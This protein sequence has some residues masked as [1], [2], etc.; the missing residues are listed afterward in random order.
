MPDIVVFGSLNADLVLTVPSLPAAG[1]TV[2]GGR[3]QTHNGGKGANQAVA[4]ARL[5]GAGQVRMVGRVGDDEYGRHLRAD[6]A[7]A[8]VD[9]AAVLVDPT[10]PSG[11]ALILADAAG[12]NMIAVSP[13]AN[14]AVD[15]SDVA[16]AAADL[17]AGDVVVCQLEVPLPAV[18]ALSTAT[19][20]AGARLVCNAAPAAM[21]DADVLAALDVLVVNETEAQVVLGAVVAGPADAAA[22]ACRAGCAVVVTLGAE[23]AVYADPDGRSGQCPAP[24]VDA[25]DTVGAGDAFVGALAVALAAGASLPDAVAAGVTAGSYAVTQV[26]ARPAPPP[27]AA[28]A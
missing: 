22:A 5:A 12:Q 4:A 15:D 7:A 13:G 26:G 19:R 21:L 28:I 20:A 6:L 16:R 2:L 25:V 8:G 3:V 18:R 1:Q 10:E 14:G 24:I 9:V 23:G 27:A 17:R 11:I